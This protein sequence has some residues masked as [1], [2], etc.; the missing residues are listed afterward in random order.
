MDAGAPSVMMDL[1]SMKQR[2]CAGSWDTL[3]QRT[4]DKLYDLGKL[5]NQAHNIHVLIMYILVLLDP[6][7]YHLFYKNN[8]I[9]GFIMNEIFRTFS[10][11]LLQ[12]IF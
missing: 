10:L 3:V 7:S 2:W 12:S 11:Y 9:F 5:V 4:M 1:E 8:L 6:I